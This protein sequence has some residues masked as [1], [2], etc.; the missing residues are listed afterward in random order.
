MSGMA[1]E[2]FTEYVNRIQSDPA[3]VKAAQR[4]LTEPIAV[5]LQRRKEQEIEK[6]RSVIH[7]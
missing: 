4:E 6:L 7:G 1:D 5:T 3:R 2:W